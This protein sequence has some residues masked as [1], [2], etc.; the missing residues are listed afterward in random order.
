MLVGA[1]CVNTRGRAWVIS[2]DIFGSTT[3][4]VGAFYMVPYTMNYGWVL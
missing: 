2:Y 4:V 1:S 3:S